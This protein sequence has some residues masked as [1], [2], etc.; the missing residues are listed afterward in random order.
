MIIRGVALFTLA[1]SCASPPPPASPTPPPQPTPK[2]LG[3]PAP[4]A[5]PRPEPAVREGEEAPF[6]RPERALAPLFFPYDRDDLGEEERARLDQVARWLQAQ[7]A[8]SIEIE[9]HCDI[10]G[11]TEY[12]LHLG[13]RRAR[14]VMKHLISRG[15]DP[16]QLRI[17]SYGE[18]RLADFGMT[19][20][21][22]ARNRRAELRPEIRGDAP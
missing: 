17:I 21:A 5:D 14:S 16:K 12:N 4:A 20:A 11:S 10:R 3:A 19:E 18:E 1:L 13:E 22:H 8:A 2:P 15:V 9:G 7:P 6:E